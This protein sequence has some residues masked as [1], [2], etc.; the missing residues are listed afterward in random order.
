MSTDLGGRSRRGRCKSTTFFRRQNK[1]MAIKRMKRKKN[2]RQIEKTQNASRI[3]YL[4]LGSF[5]FFFVNF[6]DVGMSD[7]LLYFPIV[8]SFM[9]N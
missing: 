1:R 8:S 2:T 7:S 5:L 6:V 4:F 9:F 3:V